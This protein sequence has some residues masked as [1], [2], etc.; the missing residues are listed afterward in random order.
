[1][2][3]GIKSK[4]KGGAFQIGGALE[5]VE[6]LTPHKLHQLIVNLNPAQFHLVQTIAR[7]KLGVP[8]L[9]HPDLHASELQ[10]IKAPNAFWVDHAFANGPHQLARMYEQDHFEGGGWF[11]RGKKIF[12]KVLKHGHRWFTKGK[13]LY[14]KGTHAYNQGK[15]AWDSAKQLHSTLKDMSDGNNLL[16]KGLKA[17][18]QGKDLV[19]KSKGAVTS[20]KETA[21]AAH[22]LGNDVLTAE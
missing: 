3:R 18:Q 4:T 13:D 19:D 2:P 11:S 22:D 9:S 5:H 6:N 14:Q 8:T 20:A 17:V 10:D 12:H 21:T 1:M 15:E 7:K 16:E